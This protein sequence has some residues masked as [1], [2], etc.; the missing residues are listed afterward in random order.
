MTKAY[1]ETELNW[2]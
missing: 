1:G 2:L